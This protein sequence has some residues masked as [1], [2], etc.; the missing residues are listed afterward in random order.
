MSQASKIALIAGI[1]LTQTLIQ[2]IIQ[3][4]RKSNNFYGDVA[5]LIDRLNAEAAPQVVQPP[6]PTSPDKK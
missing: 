5:P 3:Q 2:D 6:Q 1:V 4:L